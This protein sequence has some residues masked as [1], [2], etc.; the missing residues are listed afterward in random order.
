MA[1]WPDAVKKMANFYFHNVHTYQGGPNNKSPKTRKGYN[2]SLIG[3]TV[4]DDCSAFVSAC[5]I[6]FNVFPK[7][8]HP[9]SANFSNL[10][11]ECAKRL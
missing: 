1:L 10:N 11:D 7:T 9:R 5:L 8:Y 4:Y 3:G 2:C 6:F